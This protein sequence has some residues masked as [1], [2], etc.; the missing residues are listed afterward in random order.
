[1]LNPGDLLI[2]IN[3]NKLGSI[4]IGDLKVNNVYTFHSYDDMSE[5]SSRI[6]VKEYPHALFEYRFIKYSPVL[7]ELLKG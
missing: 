6:Y 1:M 4:G 7:L 3:T 2:L 5:S